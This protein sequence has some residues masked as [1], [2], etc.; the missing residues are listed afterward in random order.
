[1]KFEE[2]KKELEQIQKELEQLKES[3]QVNMSFDGFCKVCRP[4]HCLHK[5]LMVCLL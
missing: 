4:H 1:M 2:T 5:Q 3:S